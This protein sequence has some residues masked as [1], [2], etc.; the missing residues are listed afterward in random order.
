MT[1]VSLK[2][3][4]LSNINTIENKPNFKFNDKSFRE[5]VIDAGLVISN[6]SSTCIESLAFG[7]PVIILRGGSPINLNPIPNTIDKNIW[8]ECDNDVD[9]CSALERL[10]IN[11]DIV[12]QS[13]AARLIRKE[14]F[15]PVNTK[16]VNDFPEL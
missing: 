6:L 1:F 9:F 4:A 3:G 14:Y 15:E 7:V 11:K 16:S 12:A 13:N 2:I 10:F 8:D 5:L